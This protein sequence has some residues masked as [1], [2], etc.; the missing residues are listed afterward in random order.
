MRNI[1]ALIFALSLSGICFG[2]APSSPGNILTPQQLTWQ[3]EQ[4]IIPAQTSLGSMYA[5]GRG[6]PQDYVQAYLWLTLAIDGAVEDRGPFQRSQATVDLRKSI[7]DKM[8]PQQL[9]EAERLA[10]EWESRREQ[11]NGTGPYVA[12]WGVATP[13]DVFRPSPSYTD[14]ARQARI[15]GIVVVE[16]VVRKNGTVGDC[17]I[18]RG[19]GYGLDESAIQT[20]T[21][22]WR[23]Q[24]GTFKGKPV[25]VKAMAEVTFKLY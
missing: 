23:F 16:F 15:N 4:G 7:A 10:K 5:D 2:Q 13:K 18:L 3:A 24:P 19:L 1:Y 22:Q 8:T 9:E 12:G 21:T 25:D 17:K 14:R 11:R 20:I 6:V